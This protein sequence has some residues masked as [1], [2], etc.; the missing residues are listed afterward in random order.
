M[1]FCYKSKFVMA[2][3]HINR[4]SPDGGYRGN[5]PS[6][7][8]WLDKREDVQ[9]KLGVAPVQSK[10]QS[11]DQRALSSVHEETEDWYS[12][13]PLRLW[14]TFNPENN[15]LTS[16]TVRYDIENSEKSTSNDGVWNGQLESTDGF[17][18]AQSL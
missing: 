10:F 16:V 14:F 4:L 2:C 18:Q 13:H 8:S 5:M 1:L 7:I 11:P 17:C 9:R 6:G 15:S 3:F 12:I